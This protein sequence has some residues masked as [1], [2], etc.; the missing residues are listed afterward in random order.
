M[1]HHYLHP[2]IISIRQSYH[3]YQDSIEVSF[4]FLTSLMY[5]LA[6]G[7][8]KLYRAFSRQANG[9]TLNIPVLQ[10]LLIGKL[11]RCIKLTN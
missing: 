2:G 11:K 8:K 5:S 7:N 3:Y 1:N 4:T 9:L 6:F 10:G